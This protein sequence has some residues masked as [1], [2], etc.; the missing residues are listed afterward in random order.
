MLRWSLGGLAV[1]VLAGTVWIAWKAAANP[2]VR[3]RRP[4]WLPE[5]WGFDAAFWTP[6]LFTVVVGG[7]IAGWILWRAYRRIAAGEDLYAERFGRG[8]RRRGERVVSPDDAP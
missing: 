4:R 2:D 7:G 8:V 5:D 6:L 3:A 1:A